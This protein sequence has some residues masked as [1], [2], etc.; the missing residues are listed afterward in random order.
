MALDLP[1]VAVRARG[2]VEAEVKVGQAGWEVIDL[3][4]VPVEVVSALI[5]ELGYHIR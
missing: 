1:G 5:V 3:E 4:P 2:E